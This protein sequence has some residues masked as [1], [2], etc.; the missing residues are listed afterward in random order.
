MKVK[1]DTNIANYT[2]KE[3]SLIYSYIEKLVSSPGF[4][5]FLTNSLTHSC[6]LALLVHDLPGVVS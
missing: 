3:H 2:T 1:L 6:C 5:P 4:A